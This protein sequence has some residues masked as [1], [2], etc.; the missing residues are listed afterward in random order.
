MHK[1]R[2]RLTLTTV[3]DLWLSRNELAA[4]LDIAPGRILGDEAIVE[5]ALRRPNNL[6]DVA[7]IIGWRTKLDAPPFSR[8]LKTLTNSLSTPTDEQ[9]EYKVVSN[10]LPPIRVWR[11]KNPLGYARLTH[12]RAL[13]AE[14][15]AQLKIPVENLITPEFIR[16]VCWQEPPK[17][18]SDY[19]EFIKSE[20]VK[21][22]ARSWQIEQVLSPMEIAIAQMEPLVIAEPDEGDSPEASTKELE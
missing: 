15:S 7:K 19:Q 13:L 1:V 10:N 20:L 9:P 21:S 12:A 2:D 16:K 4:E 18:I 17:N 8:W 14:L 3:R 22:G 5:L 6:E 11:E